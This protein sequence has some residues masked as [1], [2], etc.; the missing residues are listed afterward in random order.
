M[1]GKACSKFFLQ[2]FDRPIC[3]L[4]APAIYGNTN[5]IDV[6]IWQREGT[7]P[8]P[9]GVGGDGVQAGVQAGVGCGG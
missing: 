4:S 3:T 9:G 5:A 7:V 2:L 1:P 8:T 6:R